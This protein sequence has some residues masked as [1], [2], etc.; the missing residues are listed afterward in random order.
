MNKLCVAVL[1]AFLCICTAASARES[2]SL[3]K[4]EELTPIKI[5]RTGWENRFTGGLI[6]WTLEFYRP[7]GKGVPR[8]KFARKTVKIEGII[9]FYYHNP[10][11]TPKTIVR[12][13]FLSR[14]AAI[15]VTAKNGRKYFAMRR[16]N[17][18][19]L[20]GIRREIK[21]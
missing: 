8:V 1:L 21:N 9:T 4:L 13:D 16:K 15:T 5:R 10:D 7:D 19:E 18:W 12:D 3:G 17:G 20:I 14:P 11:A 6:W 2:A